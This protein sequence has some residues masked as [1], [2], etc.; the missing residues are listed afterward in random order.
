MRRSAPSPVLSLPAPL[1]A[2]FPSFSALS[3]SFSTA[4]AEL[5]ALLREFFSVSG[6][7][8]V[9][10]CTGSPFW[11][12]ELPFTLVL[13]HVDLGWTVALSV[14]IGLI[15][16]SAFSAI[17]VY[18]QEL[19]PGRVGTVAGLFFGFAFGMGGL[20]AAALGF[21]ADHTSIE[22]VYKVCSFLP[23]IGL[24]TIFLPNIERPQPV[25]VQDKVVETFD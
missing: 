5:S 8:V 22:F 14:A 15:L 10:I 17:L 12:R 19:M 21:L 24:L 9:A 18:A 11:I 13:P 23:M 2:G 4:G 20:G 7:C 6:N 16:S 25:V 3:C 1:L